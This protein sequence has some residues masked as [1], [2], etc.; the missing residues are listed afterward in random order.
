MSPPTFWQKPR[1]FNECEANVPESRWMR[2]YSA[3]ANAR[4]LSIER[5]KKSAQIASRITIF[6]T[7]S[8]RAALNLTSHARQRSP[9]SSLIF[10]GDALA[11]REEAALRRQSSFVAICGAGALSSTRSLTFR[12]LAASASICFCCCA[13]FA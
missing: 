7:Y 12:T 3:F 13:I 1:C 2:K 10:L 11:R 6:G 9:V 4:S 5:A 8:P